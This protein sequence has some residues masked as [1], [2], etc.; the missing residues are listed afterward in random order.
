M[1]ITNY[2]RTI[3]DSLTEGQ[4][5]HGVTSYKLQTHRSL[6]YAI[7]PKKPKVQVP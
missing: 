2:K 1:R 6:C 4:K 7:R 3:N 5:S